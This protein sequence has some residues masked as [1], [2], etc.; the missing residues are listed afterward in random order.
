MIQLLSCLII[1]EILVNGCC[2]LFLL[3]KSL[4]LNH[5][6]V[7]FTHLKTMLVDGIINSNMVENKELKA[8]SRNGHLRHEIHSLNNGFRFQ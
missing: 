6:L 8:A 4:Q 1:T 5:W 2:F 3:R 7:L